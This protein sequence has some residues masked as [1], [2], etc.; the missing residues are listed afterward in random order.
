MTLPAAKRRVV[1]KTSKYFF[2]AELSPTFQGPITKIH[3]HKPYGQQ[4]AGHEI[5]R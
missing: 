3:E 4:R 5:F 2:D 1:R